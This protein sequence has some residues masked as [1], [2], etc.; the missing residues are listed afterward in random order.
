MPMIV[1]WVRQIIF[2]LAA[3][4]FFLF[5]VHLLIASYSLKDPF[6]FVM[7]FF[8]SNLIILISLVMV[9]AFGFQIIK[10]WKSRKKDDNAFISN[11]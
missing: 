4:F 2:I 3:I 8:A 11:D 9:I 5:G 7:T 10:Y 1:W 6:S